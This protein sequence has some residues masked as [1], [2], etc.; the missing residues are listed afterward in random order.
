VQFVFL[1]L[2]RKAI[3][4]SLQFCMQFLKIAR[5]ILSDRE[6]FPGGVFQRV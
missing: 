6:P 1:E 3:S 4:H 2:A 5:L